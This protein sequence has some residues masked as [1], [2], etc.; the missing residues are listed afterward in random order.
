MIPQLGQLGPNDQDLLIP[1]R[2][3]EGKPLPY[4]HLRY[5]TIRSEIVLIR[6][7]TGQINN[8]TGKYIMELSKPK[9]LQ[10]YMNFFELDLRW[11]ERHPQSNQ[12]S[13]IVTDSIGV[14][15]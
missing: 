3:G 2:L 4:F 1:L 9:H 13:S 11:F 8:L 6:D 7:Q 14:I 10:H 12:L 5:L 15:C